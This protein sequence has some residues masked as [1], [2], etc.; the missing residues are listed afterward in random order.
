MNQF[1]DVFNSTHYS[2]SDI[3]LSL[4][5]SKSFFFDPEIPIYNKTNQGKN[6]FISNLVDI[7]DSFESLLAVSYNTSCFLKGDY[8]QHF[9]QWMNNDITQIIDDGNQTVNIG[10]ENLF[11][12]TL[13]DGFKSTLYRF[14]ELNRYIGITYLR[15]GGN[16]IEYAFLKEYNEINQIAIDVIRPWY[17]NL[18]LLINKTFN[19]YVNATKLVNVAT[20]IVL[21]ASVIVLYFLVWR[22]YEDNLKELLKMS[23]DL[24][25]LI[26]EEIKFQIVQKLNEEENKSE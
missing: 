15:N 4:D 10:N 19:D 11:E 1:C 17:N 26:P 6:I 3:I 22:A 21:V 20:F 5:I 12:G 2:Q 18:L 23:V 14:F 16:S 8:V 25:N 9:Y 24:I 13:K 7:S